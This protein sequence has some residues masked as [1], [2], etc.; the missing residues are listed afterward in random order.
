MTSR[1][2]D[3][4]TAPVAA[5]LGCVFASAAGNPGA[6]GTAG[7]SC[8]NGLHYLPLLGRGPRPMTA[9][10]QAM[11]VE[12]EVW[13]LVDEEVPLGVL[14][15]IPEPDCTLI[16]SVAVHPEHQRQ[17]VGRRLLEWVEHE[18]ARGPHPHP[19]VHQRADGR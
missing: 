9:D 4:L 2:S 15:L 17:G 10:H 11:I 18:T 16:Y 7:E 14:E 13:L 19:P 6:H 8:E 3:A 12:H 5:D 1:V